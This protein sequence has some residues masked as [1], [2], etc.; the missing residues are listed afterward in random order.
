M[1]WFEI[2]TGVG[3]IATAIAAWVWVG[4]AAKKHL[5]DTRD[6]KQAV[7]A[8]QIHVRRQLVSVHTFDYD[9]IDWANVSRDA[10]VM[11]AVERER[12]EIE[13]W[14]LRDWKASR[15]SRAIQFE[16]QG[17]PGRYWRHFPE[18]LHGFIDELEKDYAGALDNR[19]RDSVDRHIRAA[20]NVAGLPR[21]ELFPITDTKAARTKE[22]AE[23]L[24]RCRVDI[25]GWLGP[26]LSRYMAS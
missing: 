25:E 19:S 26:P 14:G 3:A 7:E 15:L 10:G 16:H 22:I 20:Q 5:E 17:P 21:D 2:L 11:A 13:K 23:S 18:L 24:R 8:Y 4:I 1:M 9:D 12:D 6:H